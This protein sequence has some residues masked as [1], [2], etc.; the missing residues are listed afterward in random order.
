M[1]RD[2]AHQSPSVQLKGNGSWGFDQARQLGDP[3][4]GAGHGWRVLGV[5]GHTGTGARWIR[6]PFETLS[7]GFCHIPLH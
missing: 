6:A 2:K 1:C 3:G 5:H 7:A 4:C